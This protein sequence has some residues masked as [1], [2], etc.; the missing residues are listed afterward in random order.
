MS[1]RYTF[2]RGERLKSRTL[3]SRLFT[4]GKSIKHYPLRLIWLPIDQA[5]KEYPVQFALSVPKRSFRRATQRNP[6]RRRIREAYRLNKHILYE[7]L[8]KSETQYAFMVIYIAREP[9]TYATIN[10]AMQKLLVKWLKNVR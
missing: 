5:P 10:K 9:L 1:P 4:E 7:Q 6:I 2:N 3:L 8:N